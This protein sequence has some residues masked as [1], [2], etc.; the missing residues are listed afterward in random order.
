MKFIFIAMEHMWVSNNL[1]RDLAKPRGADYYKENREERM[2]YQLSYY[3]ENRKRIL[4]Y[5]IEYRKNNKE[6]LA[7]RARKKV[8]C[9]C[10]TIVNC[11]SISTHRQSKKHLECLKKIICHNNI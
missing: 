4:D 11:N 6:I 10:G 1:L 9:E 2:A 8:Q 3:K 7:E 5:H